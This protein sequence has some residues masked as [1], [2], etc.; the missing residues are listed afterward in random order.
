MRSIAKAVASDQWRPGWMPDGVAAGAQADQ[1]LHAF[2]YHRVREGN[3][4]RVEEMFRQNT[5]RRESALF[6]YLQEW[7]DDKYGHMGEFKMLSDWAPRIEKTFARAA[8]ESLSEDA[9][10]DAARCVHA[11]RDYAGKQSAED[12]GPLDAHPEHDEK[13]RRHCRNL[14]TRRSASG[15]S[16]ADLLRYVIWGPGSVAERLWRGHRDPEWKIAGIG[17]STLGEI[18]GWARPND[19][20]PRNMRTSKGLRALGHPVRIG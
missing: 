20:P 2:Y 10:V 15:R 19:Y 8:L 16:V 13:V 5:N 17:L 7:K 18:V 1:F 9:W 4:Y 3:H 11:I 14:W 6:E 12:I